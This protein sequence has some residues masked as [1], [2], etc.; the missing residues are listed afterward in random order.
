MRVAG[1]VRGSMADAA[2]LAPGDLLVALEPLAMPLRS[3]EDLRAATRHAAERETISLVVE[4]DG[5]RFSRE[6]S[7][8]ARGTEAI[9]G[10]EVRYDHV[11][12]AGARLR[13]I[14]TRPLE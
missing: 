3:P 14:V 8:Q 5:A 4:R 1:V 2:G 13:T 12:A 6:V 11:I 10:H 9:E 7:V